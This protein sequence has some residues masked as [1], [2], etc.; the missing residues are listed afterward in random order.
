MVWIDAVAPHRWSVLGEG[1]K[2][3]FLNHEDRHVPEKLE[4]KTGLTE[5]IRKIT[6]LPLSGGSVKID[7]KSAINRLSD[8]YQERLPGW[9]SAFV[10]KI[11]RNLL[12][13]GK[14]GN[15]F[16]LRKTINQANLQSPLVGF[17]E[18]GPGINRFIQS[19]FDNFDRLSEYYADQ[20]RT[21]YI[22]TFS[23]A[24]IAVGLALF[25]ISSGWLIHPN[26]TGETICIVAELLTILS[27]LY[28]VFRSYTK[29]WLGRWLDYR[30]AAEWVR[31][32]KLLAPLGIGKT[33]YETKGYQKSYVPPTA[34][35]MAWYIKNLERNLGL[36]HVRI[37]STYLV[38]YLDNILKMIQSQKLYHSNNSLIYQRIGK[39]LHRSGIAML[40]A[41]FAITFAHLLP[42]FS[43]TILLTPV[44]S[45]NLIFFSGFLPALAAALA[46]INNQGEFKRMAKS[47]GAMQHEYDRLSLELSGLQKRLESQQGKSVLHF[48]ILL[49]DL[50]NRTAHLAF[51]E[52]SDWGVTYQNR[53]LSL[54]V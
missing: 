19:G 27:I 38:K 13:R 49:K 6:S 24:A 32:M 23:L 29:R 18:K 22:L 48:Y 17:A 10:W 41:T 28:I 15:V 9:N 47:S 25:P 52:L 53:P 4:D 34:T 54:P 1:D 37:D 36:P 20:H 3:P 12:G 51:E 46:G 40:V 31:Q 14:L 30:L 50:A 43:K 5:L 11:F 16:S 2:L 39:K 21:G 35:W 8:F 44:L 7:Q 26:P 45:Q 33:I 42:L